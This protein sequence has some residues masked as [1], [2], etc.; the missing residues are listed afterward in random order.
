MSIE[1]ENALASAAKAASDSPSAR[2][3]Q[4]LYTLLS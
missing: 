2:A 4:R 1:I 3:K